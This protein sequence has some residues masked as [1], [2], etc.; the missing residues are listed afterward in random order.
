MSAINT[1]IEKDIFKLIKPP[2]KTYSFILF[3]TKF[4]YF[5]TGL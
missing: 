4:N 1:Y 5:Y 3:T 2:R